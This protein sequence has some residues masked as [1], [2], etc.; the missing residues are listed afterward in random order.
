MKCQGQPY[1]SAHPLKCEFHAL[2]SLNK[3][4]LAS[5]RHD[6]VLPAKGTAVPLDYRIVFTDW[7]A[8]SQ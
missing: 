2:A 7:T 8:S 1:R 3:F 5:S 4:G 6:L